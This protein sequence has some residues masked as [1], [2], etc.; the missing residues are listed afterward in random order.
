MILPGPRR[1][2]VQE[3]ALPSLNPST[4]EDILFRYIL[5]ALRDCP[6][7]PA[8]SHF[9]QKALSFRRRAA[10]SARA[11]FSEGERFSSIS[12]SRTFT[13]RSGTST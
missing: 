5:V 6:Q 10:N 7:T 13:C 9:P 11:S 8:G 2:L 1:E 4:D 3:G 12:C